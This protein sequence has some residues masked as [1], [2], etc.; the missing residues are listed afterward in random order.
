M[1]MGKGSALNVGGCQVING[2][3]STNTAWYVGA[4]NLFKGVFSS[5]SSTGATEIET[6]CIDDAIVW[7]GTNNAAPSTWAACSTDTTKGWVRVP[8]RDGHSHV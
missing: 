5:F 8:Q 6:G 3:V 1:N 2:Y 4:G 7:D